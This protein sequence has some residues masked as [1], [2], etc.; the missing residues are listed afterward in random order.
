MQATR[1]SALALALV[2][3]VALVC[4]SSA[5]STVATTTVG[6]LH[7]PFYEEY[8]LSFLVS[9]I[10]QPV[11]VETPD[12][13]DYTSILAAAQRLTASGVSRIFVWANHP[14]A[15]RGVY[16][17]G[18]QAANL[19]CLAY[20][21][22]ELGFL[23][24]VLAASMGVSRIGM[25]GYEAPD[26]AMLAVQTGFR[27]GVEVACVQA[28][29]EVLALALPEEYADR[30]E[31]DAAVAAAARAA[32][33][34]GPEVLFN[35]DFATA[36][37]VDV[38]T[39]AAAAGLLVIESGIDE[40][41]SSYQSGALAGS[42]NLLASVIIRYDL[43]ARALARRPFSGGVVALGLA[44]GLV[45]VTP[46]YLACKKLPPQTPAALERYRGL[47]TAGAMRTGVDP[48]TGLPV[49][50]RAGL[51]LGPGESV[52][53]GVYL[54]N[55]WEGGFT[56][57]GVSRALARAASSG[58]ADV[59]A[60]LEALLAAGARHVFLASHDEAFTA[61]VYACARSRYAGLLFTFVDH[62][63]P[64]AGPNIEGAAFADGEVGFL[65][66]VLAGAVSR[67]RTVAVVSGPLRV[68]P[69]RRAVAGFAR[70]VAHA[71]PACT[72]LT[73]SLPPSPTAPPGPRPG[74]RPRG[75]GGCGV[76]L[77]RQRRLRRH[78]A[79]SARGAPAWVIGVDADEYETTF[80]GGRA[81]GA[82]RLL[83]SALKRTETAVRR[84]IALATERHLAHGRRRRGG[85][86]GAV[87]RGVR[88][89]GTGAVAGAVR[90]AREGL[91]RGALHTGVVYDTGALGLLWDAPA[92]LG[93]TVAGLPQTLGLYALPGFGAQ[94]SL[95][96]AAAAPG[97]LRAE[98]GARFSVSFRALGGQAAVRV[99]YL[100]LPPNVRA[101][102]R[103][104]IA[105]L[106]PRAAVLLPSAPASAGR[107]Q[108]AVPAAC[109]ALLLLCS[110]P[111]GAPVASPPA[112]CWASA[113]T[114]YALAAVCEGCAGPAP[115]LSG[116]TIFGILLCVLFAVYWTGS[117][118]VL[119]YQRLV[120]ARLAG[121]GSRGAAPKP[122]RPSPA[123][124]ETPA[125]PL[126]ADVGARRCRAPRGAPLGTPSTPA[127]S[128]D[129][130]LTPARPAPHV[131]PAPPP[132]PPRLPAAPPAAPPIPA[133]PAK[134]DII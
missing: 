131:A 112:A 62:V 124:L 126:L 113:D 21:L 65:A 61:A 9:A 60:A 118:L 20:R 106:A 34:S 93:E 102:P 80:E 74:R 96:S 12:N 52:E 72:V 119:G 48:A 23:A 59:E 63:A 11:R 67:A 133:P 66:G 105:A 70:G 37:G 98:P 87:P 14:C 43:A 15:I 97:V 32:I 30:P 86:P 55:I 8:E 36:T 45:E 121:R 64:G 54:R 47:L 109:S 38:S 78:P 2:M 4:G 17:G 5:G 84:S 122:G 10:Q 75:G 27:K 16:R 31:Y 53:E 89:A 41:Y 18:A 6:L 73:R 58:A 111:A 81:P 134:D 33:A 24:G 44:A 35:S 50:W 56:G 46:C 91:A 128:F 104:A 90:R 130:P 7:E 108:L 99:E 79:A 94:P 76:R 110:A 107:A 69:V 28:A 129:V 132:P 77:R 127:P 117:G 95:L 57:L 71:C 13:D 40:F 22:D 26:P 39:R 1:G 123:G 3:V 88:V 19:E 101:D 100:C 85:R 29:C 115:P 103:A 83:S 51:L 49:P 25:L 82:G 68:L 92:Q 42:A 114:V 116:G 120:A 125:R